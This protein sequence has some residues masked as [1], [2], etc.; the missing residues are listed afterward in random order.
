MVEA[1][2]RLSPGAADQSGAHVDF[3]STPRFWRV[4]RSYR[5]H[6]KHLGS[7]GGS[8]NYAISGDDASSFRVSGSSLQLAAEVAADYETKTSYSI[9]IESTDSG[10]LSTSKDFTITVIDAVEGRVVDAP[11]RGS[12]VFIDLNGNSVQDS[13][14]P[15]GTSDANGFFIVENTVTGGSPK[16][17][18]IGGTDTKTESLF[19]IWP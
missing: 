12:N 13:D 19:R 8:F 18:S 3:L 11:L 1:V 4:L 16:I 10:N 5:W 15:N 9:T 14:E 6:V 2:P 17:I 7:D